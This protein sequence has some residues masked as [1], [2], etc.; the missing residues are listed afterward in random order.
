MQEGKALYGKMLL[1]KQFLSF[2]VGDGG[3]YFC[4]LMFGIQQVVFLTSMDTELYVY[5]AG[6]S[7]GHMLS[8]IIREGEWFRPR[9]R[10]NH[11]VEIQSRLPKISIGNEDLPVWRSTS[12]SYSCAQTWEHLRIKLHVVEWHKFVWFAL[13]I[14]KHAFILWLVF[15][16]ALIT[17]EKMYLW[18]YEGSSL[19]LFCHACQENGDHIFFSCN[20]TS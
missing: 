6:R 20:F 3:R 16:N 17:K 4:G 7:I 5:D 15:R 2:K 12:S 19:C 8:T 1:A 11:L 9:A 13:A 14:P 18:G 10:S